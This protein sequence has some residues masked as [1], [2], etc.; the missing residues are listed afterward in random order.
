MAYK[1][2][3]RKNPQKVVAV[4]EFEMV[5]GREDFSED[6]EDKQDLRKKLIG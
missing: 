6:K 2:T 3:R 4:E 5:I 1:I